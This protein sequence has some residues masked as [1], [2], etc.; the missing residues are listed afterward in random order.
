[1]SQ[2]IGLLLPA[3]G[4]SSPAEDLP[5]PAGAFPTVGANL[6]AV[7][8]GFPSFGGDF[9]AVGANLLAADDGANLPP[10]LAGGW[11]NFAHRAARHN[12]KGRRR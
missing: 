12:R 4:L 5:L 8:A 11:R 7:G 6:L 9:R 1:M 3:G 10:P 2:R